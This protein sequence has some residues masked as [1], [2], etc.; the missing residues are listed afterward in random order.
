M[1][2]KPVHTKLSEAAQMATF[3]MTPVQLILYEQRLASW[4]LPGHTLTASHDS[5]WF[6]LPHQQA[7]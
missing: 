7:G 6:C 4:V 1:K 2:E 3:Q 5:T